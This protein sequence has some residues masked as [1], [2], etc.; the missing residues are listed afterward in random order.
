M[1]KG[2][3]AAAV[4]L[5]ASVVAASGNGSFSWKARPGGAAVDAQLKSAAPRPA[6][7]T[8]E[9]Q[10]RGLVFTVPAAWSVQRA[11][12][13]PFRSEYVGVT[14]RPSG[15]RLTFSDSVQFARDGS[16]VVGPA[17]ADART[18]SGL[19]MERFEM[20]NPMTRGVVYVF[21][22]AGVSMSA[23]VRTDAEARAADA[24]AW[25]ARRALPQRGP[26]RS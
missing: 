7:G 3:I 8:R 24:V 23:Q 1:V 13:L 20:P 5:A 25:S 17:R 15:P 14:G 10:F 22:E 9:F 6:S 11:D 4:T 26:A 19:S 12:R 21:P 18:G 2:A 16:A